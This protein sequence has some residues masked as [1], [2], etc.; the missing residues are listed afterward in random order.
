MNSSAASSPSASRAGTQGTVGVALHG[1]TRVPPGVGHRVALHPTARFERFRRGVQL[2][3]VP[4]AGAHVGAQRQADVG[5]GEETDLG[6]VEAVARPCR[7]VRVAAVLAEHVAEV[8]EAGPG[9]IRLVPLAAQP[10]E[11]RSSLGAQRR[12][13]PFEQ[14]GRAPSAVAGRSQHA[15]ELGDGTGATGRE[16]RRCVGEGPSVADPVDDDDRL[17]HTERG[18]HDLGLDLAEQRTATGEVRRPV[19]HR[20]AAQLAW[21]RRESEA[22]VCRVRLGREVHL[23]D[24]RLEAGGE[25]AGRD[26]E[27]VVVDR[28]RGN[29]ASDWSARPRPGVS[30]V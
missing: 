28:H 19:G 17:E 2:G 20:D 8:E 27:L 16:D 23:A 25:R 1:F 9:I 7:H 15:L 30:G 6:R 10:G 29:V 12:D 22:D 21:A 26:P 18:R 24:E 5:L 3:V 13:G 11:Q 14:S 4:R